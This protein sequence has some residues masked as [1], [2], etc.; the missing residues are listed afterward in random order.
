[1]LVVLVS[2]SPSI[3]GMDSDPYPP[4]SRFPCGSV[5]PFPRYSKYFPKITPLCKRQAE[6]PIRHSSPMVRIAR[7]GSSSLVFR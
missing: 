2:Q 4:R 7:P 3:R 5:R 1:M 6:S